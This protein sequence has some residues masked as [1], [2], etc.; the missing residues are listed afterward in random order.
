MKIRKTE[1]SSIF[2]DLHTDWCLI[3]DV[4]LQTWFLARSVFISGSAG[5]HFNLQMAVMM[6]HSQACEPWR[7]AISRDVF[8]WTLTPAET[9]GHLKD[10]NSLKVF[11]ETFHEHDQLVILLFWC[12]RCVALLDTACVLFSEAW[13]HNRSPGLTSASVKQQEVL[14]SLF[15]ILCLNKLW[16]TNKASL[17]FICWTSWLISPFITSLIHHSIHHWHLCDLHD[18]VSWWWYQLNIFVYPV[19]R[20]RSQ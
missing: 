18:C 4:T 2:W 20:R 10:S 9:R 11:Y 19:R 15:L 7:A 17:V 1:M 14:S 5:A 12:H 8:S 3:A 16:I 6:R 13:T